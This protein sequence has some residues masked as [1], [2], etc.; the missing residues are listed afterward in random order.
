MGRACAR[1]MGATYDLVL[2]DVANGALDGFAAELV[3]DGYGIVSARAGDLN[4]SALLDAL[5]GDLASERPFGLVHTAGL[6][7]ALGDWRAIMTINLI[8]TDKLLNRIEPVLQPGS[9]GVVIAST[10]GHMA[11]AGTDVTGMLD[12]PQAAGFL[13]QIGPIIGTIAKQSQTGPEGISYSLSK[14]AVIRQCE[15]R[16]SVWGAKGARIASISPGLILTPMGRRE[17]EKTDGAAQLRDA[18]PLGRAGAPMDIALA[19]QF[20]LSDAASFITG[21]DLRVDGGSVA[22]INQMTAR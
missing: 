5:V 12:A 1:L 15:R 18:A 9:V 11:I 14:A 17:L 19:A 21:T 20:L 13:D 7:P 4:Q 8:A 3:R 2:T 10:A 22:F 6:S 16:A